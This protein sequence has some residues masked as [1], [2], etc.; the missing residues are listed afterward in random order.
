MVYGNFR[1]FERNLRFWEFQVVCE[2]F[3]RIADVRRKYI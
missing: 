1:W 2:Y 3:K